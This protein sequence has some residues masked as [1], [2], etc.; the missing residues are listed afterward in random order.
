MDH[1]FHRMVLF[2]IDGTLL[3]TNGR[4]VKALEDAFTEVYGVRPPNDGRLMDGKTELAIVYDFAA[5]AGLPRE[6]VPPRLEALWEAY[7]FLLPQRMSAEHITVHPGVKDLLRRLNAMEGVLV[8]L[9][10]GNCE[11]SSR[12][13]L[14]AAGLEEEFALGAFGQYH[15]SRMDLPPLALEAA[16]LEWGTVF[17][18]RSVV[19]VGDTPADIACCRPLGWTAVAVATGRYSLEDLAAHQPGH[20]FANL[21][22]PRVLNTVLGR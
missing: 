4:A 3:D 13:K 21:A 12:L 17:P 11:E 9:L 1:T 7:F 8:G 15:E 5:A 6:A 2:D 16:R 19:V 14:S 20:L 22:D 18:G 10:T